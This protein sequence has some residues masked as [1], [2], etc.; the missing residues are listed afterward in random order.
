[1]VLSSDCIIMFTNG[2]IFC[3]V[4]ADL[5]AACHL[6]YPPE[7]NAIVANLASSKTRGFYFYKTL[8]SIRISKEH[9]SKTTQK[10]GGGPPFSKEIPI[11]KTIIK[12]AK[13]YYFTNLAFNEIRGPISLLFATFWGLHK[14]VWGRELIWPELVVYGVFFQQKETPPLGCP[15]KLVNG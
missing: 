8:S 15:R 6:S 4:L 13:L 5:R 7:F 10:N 3:P 11:R 2:F 14:P 1:M 9:H 12:L